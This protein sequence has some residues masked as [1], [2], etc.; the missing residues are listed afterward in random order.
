MEGN[1][2][3]P[4]RPRR[5]TRA[6]AQPAQEQAPRPEPVQAQAAPAPAPKLKKKKPAARKAR[7]KA[8]PAPTPAQPEEEDIDDLFSDYEEDEQLGSDPELDN[9]F[10]DYEDDGKEINGLS[11]GEASEEGIYDDAY[12]EVSENEEEYE[13]VDED[14]VEDEY[15]DEELEEEYLTDIPRRGRREEEKVEM[16]D[17]ILFSLFGYYIPALITMAFFTFLFIFVLSEVSMVSLSPIHTTEVSVHLAPFLSETDL[18]VP[19]IAVIL[20]GADA[21]LHIKD[22][23]RNLMFSFIPTGIMLMALGMGVYSTNPDVLGNISAYILF[24]MMMVMLLLDFLAYLNFP[25]L[26]EQTSRDQFEEMM[27]EDDLTELRAQL[28]RQIAQ[29]EQEILDEEE[30]LQSRAEEL[31]KVQ[32]ELKGKTEELLEEEEQLSRKEQQ[33]SQLES[34][35]KVKEEEVLLEEE[36]KVRMKQEEIEQ[37]KEEAR[38]QSDLLDESTEEIRRREEELDALKERLENEIRQRLQEEEKQRYRE[39][40]SQASKSEKAKRTLFPFAAV[41]GQEKMKLSLLLNAIDN[42]I[43]GVL[44]LGQKGTAKSVA[45]R[46]LSEVL[47]DIKI[48]EGCRFNCD[49]DT[50]DELC[51]ECRIKRSREGLT[52]FERPIRV[53]DLPLNITEDRLVGSIDIEKILSEGSKAFEPGLLAEAHRGILYVDEINLLDD[54][55]VDLLLD[56]AAMGI[57][58]VEREGLHISHPAEFIIIGSMNPEEGELRPQLIDRLGLEI[59]IE[60]IKDVKQR[61]QI[62]DARKEYSESPDKFRVKYEPEQN[63]IREKIINA[64]KLLPQ[65]VTPPKLLLIIAKI[66]VEFGVHGHR[67]DII[68]NRTARAHAAWEGR[69]EVT[70]EDIVTASEMAL[71]HRMRKMPLEEE[72]FDTDMIRRLVRAFE[73]GENE[74]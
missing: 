46:G 73:V 67:A 7:P 48:I 62:I 18:F 70:I 55:I 64:K 45:I 13:Y 31:N 24:L 51:A 65:V 66:C 42:S 26:L 54:Y 40:M 38:I 41:V 72:E 49:P 5:R 34:D 1:P 2:D 61:I 6:A 35:L 69:L 19:V 30:R 60:G 63:K 22:S 3:T 14:E 52:V 56:A 33:L 44:I 71:P 8:Q 20:S 57:N 23:K 37:L 47:P 29:K 4:K 21:Y 58:T 9:L 11:L 25:E 27:P 16:K 28:E 53:V 50:P 59:P 10:E 39:A 36:E 15:V 74:E 17:L 68:I 12:E 32:M 43:G